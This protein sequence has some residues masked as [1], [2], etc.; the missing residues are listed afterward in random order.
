MTVIISG[1][2]HRCILDCGY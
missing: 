1:C 2:C